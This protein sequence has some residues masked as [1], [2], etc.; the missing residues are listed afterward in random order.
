MWAILVAIGVTV[1]GYRHRPCTNPGHYGLSDSPVDMVV[2]TSVAGASERDQFTGWSD[3]WWW[4]AAAHR[5][6]FVVG[7]A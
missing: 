7:A 1:P 3:G 4:A 6:D 5:V 2:H